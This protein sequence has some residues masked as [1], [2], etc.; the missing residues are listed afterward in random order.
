MLTALDVPGI[1]WVGFWPPAL[2]IRCCHWLPES[3]AQSTTGCNKHTETSDEKNQ[4]KSHR[5]IPAL[6]LLIR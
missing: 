5:M 1:F 3:K 4:D 2:A 6:P